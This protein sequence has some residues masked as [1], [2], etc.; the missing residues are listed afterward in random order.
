[1]TTLP[2]RDAF[3]L[4][5]GIYLDG[6]SLGPLPIAAQAA[7]ERR[8]RQWQH[9]AVH[10]W[11]EWFALAERLSPALGR[12]VG[13]HGDEV[14]STGGITINLHALLAT[15]YHPEGDRRALLASELEFG[16]D[17]YA[18]RAW[19][20][21]SGGSLELI[22][23]RDGHTLH[24]ADID[25]AL[26]R[27]VALAWLPTV[28]YRSGQALDVAAITRIGRERGV[29]MG[30]D[31]AHSI[32]ALPHAFHRHGVDFAVWC[33]YKYL[34]AGP[35]APGGLFVHRRWHMRS[36]GLPGWWGND[37]S[38]QFEMAPDFRRASGAGAFQIGTQ[39]ILALAGLEGALAL[40]EEV[41]IDEIRARS[42]ELTG[43]LIERTEAALPDLTLRT[44]RRA[45]ERG[46]H[47]AFE[48]PEALRLGLALRERHIT[49]D[50]R[51]PNLLRIAPVALYNT[52]DEIDTV[53]DT[54]RE[55]LASGAHLAIDP[56]SQ[57]T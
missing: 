6:N 15:F 29:L 32:G 2:R 42:L 16:S 43:Y 21:R 28:L 41:G 49:P 36:P 48:H 5:R 11:D 25:A 55:L 27:G 26:H 4:P 33:S 54:L 31:A 20:E 38:S 13:A 45:A 56:D 10:A 30:W 37:K 22:P 53:I 18:L 14:I 40:F 51:P 12:L 19:A 8:M 52:R 57:V 1:M 34:N 7:I 17:L 50:F 35:G 9:R 24:P 3:L 23:S 46:G 47:V 39:S 44:P